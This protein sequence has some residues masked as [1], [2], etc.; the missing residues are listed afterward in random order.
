MELK[1]ERVEEMGRELPRAVE[2]EDRNHEN[3]KTHEGME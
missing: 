3:E 1:Q 2:Y